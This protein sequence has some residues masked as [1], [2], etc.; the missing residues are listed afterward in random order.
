MIRGMSI[1]DLRREYNLT[2]LRRA[3]LAPDPMVQF[4]RWFDQ[5]AGAR[6]S[7]R[8]RKLL[9]RTYKSLLLSAGAEPLDVNAMTLATADKDGRPSARIVLLK[10]LNSR[11]FIFYTNYD[12]RKGRELAQN[13]AASLV[14]YWGEQERQ[15]CVAGLVERLPV[16]ESEAYFKSRP[17]GSRIGAWASRQSEVV[18]DRAELE[19]RWREIEAKYPGQEIPKPENWGGFVLRPARIEFWQGRPSRMHDRFRYSRQADQSWAIE[20]LAP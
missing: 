1:A 10:G 4:Q 14:F 3:D 6:A 13:S 7:G 5:A 19:A 11:G 18:R 8:L 15:V 17:R 9:I 2:G 16:E 12:S 20:R